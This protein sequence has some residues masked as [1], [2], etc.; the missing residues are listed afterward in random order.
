MEKEISQTMEELRRLND[1]RRME[2]LQE[3]VR[4]VGITSGYTVTL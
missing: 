1:L 4:Y 3:Q 2:A